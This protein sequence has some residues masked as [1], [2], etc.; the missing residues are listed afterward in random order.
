MALVPLRTESNGAIP[1]LRSLGICVS[2][3]IH[4]SRHFQ[5][6]NNWSLVQYWTSCT[7]MLVWQNRKGFF[8]DAGQSGQSFQ[9]S[10]MGVNIRNIK[11]RRVQRTRL[12]FRPL[13]TFTAQ[14]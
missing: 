10:Y 2:F 5:S 3:L 12:F 11:D 6:S 14:C 1:E 7:P 4:R 9:K 13:S 8:Q